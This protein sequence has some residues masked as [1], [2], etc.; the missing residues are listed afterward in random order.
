MPQRIEDHSVLYLRCVL[1]NVW[2]GAAHLVHL[3]KA[4]L[5]PGTRG[6]KRSAP[7]RHPVTD[8]VGFLEEIHGV[9]KLELIAEPGSLFSRSR[10]NAGEAHA[11]E[12][13]DVMAVEVVLAVAR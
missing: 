1:S 10:E 9:G 7:G 12:V 4:V 3:V 11:N 13:G 6:A 5:A 8:D 2:V